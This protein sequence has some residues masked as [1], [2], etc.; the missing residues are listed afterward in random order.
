MV[1]V[2][3][4][5]RRNVT[6]NDLRKDASALSLADVS[7]SIKKALEATEDTCKRNYELVPQNITPFFAGKP[8]PKILVSLRKCTLQ[9]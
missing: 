7:A 3:T 5:L 1:L 4:H 8:L 6:I 9:R 2:K